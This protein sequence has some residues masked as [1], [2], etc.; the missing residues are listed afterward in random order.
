[1][2]RCG[3]QG[4]RL[5]IVELFRS[6]RCQDQVCISSRRTTVPRNVGADARNAVT[7][8]ADRLVAGAYV[9][10]LTGERSGVPAETVRQLLFRV[11]VTS[12]SR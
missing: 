7:A 11:V 9:L 5:P 12:R 1:M 10:T 3:A 6:E 4:A 2:Y 8:P